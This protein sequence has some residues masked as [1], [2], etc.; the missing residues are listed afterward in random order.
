[1]KVSEISAR[2]RVICP[3]RGYRQPKVSIVTPTY[4]RNAEGL[5]AKCLDSAMAQTFE[6]L[7]GMVEAGEMALPEESGRLLPTAIYARWLRP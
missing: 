7:G 6:G 5:L 3:G 4:R 1:M 2:G